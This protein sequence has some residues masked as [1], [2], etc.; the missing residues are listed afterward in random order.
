[1]AHRPLQITLLDLIRLVEYGYSSF[2][3]DVEGMLRRGSEAYPHYTSDGTREIKLCLSHG[4]A[5]PLVKILTSDAGAEKARLL[6]GFGS[7]RSRN[8]W[9]MTG[10]ITANAA[11]PVLWAIAG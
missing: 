2:R 10:V 6:A 7:F 3:G 4:I 11:L 9:P 5:D 1:M 8:Q